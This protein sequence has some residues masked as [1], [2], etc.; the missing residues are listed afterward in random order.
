MEETDVEHLSRLFPDANV[1]QYNYLDDDIDYI[2][3]KVKM[4]KD[5][6]ASKDVFASYQKL[7][8]KLIDD[9]N[10]PNIKWI[11]LINPPFATAQT[12][13]AN[14][15]SKA[16]VS[17]T[18]IRRLMHQCNLGEV[19]RELFSQFLF[20]IKYEFADKNTHLAIFSTL[21]YLN[22]TNDAKF[23]EFI[24]QFEFIRGFVFSSS[25]F[26]GTAKGNGFPVGCIVWNLSNSLKLDE[27]KI[28]L[29]YSM[30]KQE[31]LAKKALEW[32][33]KKCF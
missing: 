6:L 12:S 24:F 9:L 14:S 2:A 23:R 17:I 33:T 32:K 21:K 5:K 1:F 31:R 15:D 18:N 10:N 26:S 28:V 4:E 13:G 20:R 29:D 27:Q 30:T 3:A 11:I 7:P 25:N 22:A 8:Q 16:G 19:S